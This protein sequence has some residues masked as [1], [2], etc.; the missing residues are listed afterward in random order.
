MTDPQSAAGPLINGIPLALWVTIAAV[1]FAP[2][3]ALFG[4]LRSNSNARKNLEQQVRHDALQRDRERE[5]SLRREVYLEAASALV[6]LQTLVGKAG[7]IEYDQK[8]LL[9]AFGKDQS[10]IAKTHIVGSQETVA[11][12]MAFVGQM[13]PAF[14]EM[15]TRRVPL[16]IR[17]SSIDTHAALRDQAMSERERFVGM[18]QRC[19]LE[20]INEPAK[21]E[22][23]NRQHEFASKQW[24]FH[25]G[26]RQR[27]QAEQLQAQ[28]LIAE[29]SM[30]L[31]RALIAHLPNAVLAVR[32]EMELQLDRL[33][34]E[35][36][37]QEQVR[38][39]DEAWSAAKGRLAIFNLNQGQE[40]K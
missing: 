7:N 20:G 3:V 23:I 2:I 1:V 17:K 34:Y 39:M 4:T 30:E 14:L 36:E 5:M 22:A 25:E 21:I 15:I 35:S 29:R 12:V 33:F 6:H 31:N 32:R 27:L 16:V 38:K 28:L 19:N 13:G 40:E 18:L 24:D 10:V 11:A 8:D 37:W 9:D 26:E